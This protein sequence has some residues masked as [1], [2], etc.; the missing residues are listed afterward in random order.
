MTVRLHARHVIV[1]NAWL[2]ITAGMEN[3]LRA[4]NLSWYDALYY[5][6]RIKLQL[7]REMGATI[8]AEVPPEETPDNE[9]IIGSAFYQ[10]MMKYELTQS[11]LYSLITQWETRE[12]NGM[13][14]D[15]RGLL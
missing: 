8:L 12:A 11:E 2:E 14:K 9:H 13:L 10:P 5:V 6:A 3:V 4:L 1:S 15:E 7:L